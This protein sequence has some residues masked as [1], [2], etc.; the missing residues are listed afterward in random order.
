MDAL[1]RGLEPEA[2]ARLQEYID[3]AVAA[4]L[5]TR[6]ELALEALVK[7]IVDARLQLGST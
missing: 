1:A 6:L 7:A 2:Q 5:S 4:Q 3:A